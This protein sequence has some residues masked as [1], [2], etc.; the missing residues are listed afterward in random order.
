MKFASKSARVSIARPAFCRYPGNYDLLENT[1]TNLIWTDLPFMMDFITHFPKRFLLACP[2]PKAGHRLSSRA[3]GLV[4]AAGL[5]V[6]GVVGTLLLSVTGWD[7]AWPASVYRPGAV[8]QGW[9]YARQLPWRRLYD[10]GEI[11]TIL[12]MVGA[13]LVLVAQ[14]FGKV[15]TGYRRPCLVVVLT[16]VLG[17]GLVVNGLLKPLWGRP[18]PAD[19]VQFGG[20]WQYRPVWHPGKPGEGKSFPSGHCASA[21]ALASLAAFYPWHPWF[22]V[23]VLVGATAYGI[24]MGGARVVQGGHYPTDALWSGV[25]VFV[26][27][28]VLY[29]VVFRVPETGPANRERT[30]RDREERMF[31]NG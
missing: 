1:S 11:P 22:G 26:V 14:F 7:L 5:L 16:V 18:R 15:A 8:N 17:P 24:L 27:V 9:E 12:L 28:V 2:P 6:F 4:I 10:Y 21:F 23:S 25:I 20:A 3:K 31:E 29:Y 30:V 19:T 13:V